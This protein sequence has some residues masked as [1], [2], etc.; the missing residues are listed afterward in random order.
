M[1]EIFTRISVRDYRPDPV[2]PDKVELILRAAMQAPSARNQQ[3]WEF[4]VVDDRGL[5]EGLSTASPYA[6][7]VGRAP[8]AVVVMGDR[9]RM[10][11]PQMWEQDL[12]ACTQN[13][14][15]EARHLG[16]GTVWIGI[17]PVQD[18]MDRI[19]DLLGLPDNMVPFCIVAVGYPREEPVP[20]A[21]RYDPSRVHRNGF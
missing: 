13:L 19:S 21:S 16:L 11:V 6:G 15:L 12:G 2:E 3:A 17:A 1:D 8:M 9:D 7:P 14:M 5:I 10:T 20:H 18:R 4:V